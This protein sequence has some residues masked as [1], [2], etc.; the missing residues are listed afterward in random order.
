[1]RYEGTV[2]RPPSEAIAFLFRLVSAVPIISVLFA[3][4]I[5]VQNSGCVR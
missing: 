2:Y 1:M 4:C 3:V 5:K